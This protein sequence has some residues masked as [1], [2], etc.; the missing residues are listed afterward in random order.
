MPYGWKKM[1]LLEKILDQKNKTGPI[2]PDWGL[3]K[4]KKWG[5][6]CNYRELLFGFYR[7][8]VSILCKQTFHDACVI[9][10]MR[11]DAQQRSRVIII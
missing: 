8:H 1:P 6:P 9:N 10:M 4:P 5:K 3:L 2:T 7:N 11:Y